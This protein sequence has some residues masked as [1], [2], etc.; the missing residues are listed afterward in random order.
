PST[1]LIVE[2]DEAIVTVDVYR[3]IHDGTYDYEDIRHTWS[4]HVLLETSVTL[5]GPYNPSMNRMSTQLNTLGYIPT[6]SPYP[7]D[8]RVVPAIPEDV[9]DWVLVELRSHADS[10]VFAV[11][12]AFLRNDGSIVD[13]DGTTRQIQIPGTEG[14]YHVVVSHRNHLPVMSR[15]PVQLRYSS[16]ELYDFTLGAD[17]YYGS[18]AKLLNTDPVVYGMYD[19]DISGD[20]VIRLADELNELRINNLQFGYINADVDLNGVVSLASELTQVRKNNLQVTKVK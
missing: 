7:E 11:R 15:E 13:D 19:A 6:T 17:R 16:S 1:F 12:S 2:V 9:T 10:S 18:A 4:T 14:A 8:P 20:G 5:E 3:E